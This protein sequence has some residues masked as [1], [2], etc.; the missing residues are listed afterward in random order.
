MT[1]TY[2]VW[3]TQYCK[4]L[5]IHADTKDQAILKAQE[6]MTWEVVTAEFEAEKIS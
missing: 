6:D 4:P 3:I 5:T 2:K 1:D